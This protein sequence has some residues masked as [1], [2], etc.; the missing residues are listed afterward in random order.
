MSDADFG[1]IVPDVADRTAADL[2][3]AALVSDRVA[4]AKALKRM[5]NIDR[6][7]VSSD[8]NPTGLAPTARDLFNATADDDR[9]YR[10]AT[11]ELLDG[12]KIDPALRGRLE[13]VE[14]DDPLALANDRIWDVRQ[15]KFGKAF[16]AVAEPL[17]RSI[18]TTTMAPYRLSRALVNYFIDLLGQEPILLQERQA[19]VHWETFLARHPDAPE[20]EVL[21]PRVEDA[22]ARLS[23]THRD[24]AMRVAKRALERDQAR[25]ALIYSDRALRYA[26]EDG[27]ASDL[28]DEA[29][30]L[31][32]L[33][34][35]QR[36]RSLGRVGGG[37]VEV[38]PAEA[39]PLVLAMLV[40]GGDM[41]DAAEELLTSDPDGPLADE[42]LFALAIAEGESGEE[43]EMWDEI[44]DLADEDDEDSN[45]ARHARALLA[46]PTTNPYG[47]FEAKVDQHRLQRVMWVLFGPMFRG[48][49]PRN[50]PTALNWAIDAP[51]IA[52][53]LFGSP[54]R[55]LQLPWTPDFPTA[56]VAAHHAREY[57]EQNPDGEHAEDVRDW[58]EDFEEHR[59][60]WIAA[61]AVAENDP[62][63][64]PEEIEEMREKA[65][66]QILKTAT[67]EER[68]DMRLLLYQR[69]ARD[70]PT[71]QAGRRAGEYA[72][73]DA[74]DSTQHRI[75]ISRGFLEENPAVAGPRGFALL[76]R[77]LDEDNTNGE[78]H[79]V[80]VGLIGGLEIETAYV[81][82]DGDPDELPVM[83]TE[84]VSE[85]H[86][87][88]IVSQ[89]E[90]T[91]FR[92]AL[93]DADDPVVPDAQR[94]T[95]FERARLGL[96]DEVDYRALAQSS[97]NYTGMR[98]RYGV[99]R[100]R[101]S[102]LPFE[103]VIQGS[104]TDMSLG[105]FPRVLP[106]R[107]TLR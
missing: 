24:R 3:A 4:A 16:N 53:S 70:Y 89:L 50:L 33:Q 21:L 25:L 48:P 92:N 77:L 19:L 34:R 58:L 69:V 79:P 31:L 32:I 96:G 6:V 59:E 42:A 17:G 72:R 67:E 87:A 15:I 71:T 64:D 68:R 66:T 78:L 82:P 76:P 29:A 63:T 98:E 1:A 52:E 56:R 97:F 40:P 7:L 41:Q 102:I 65:A 81:R 60:N 27:P 88:R 30:R 83:H 86:L 55:L 37:D 23:R 75:Q 105:A 104:F 28:R 45:M 26:P 91:S 73:L 8:E 85:D 74:L 100:G 38:A 46:Q 47:A 107:S 101:D 36:S 51:R 49:K 14:E 43:E 95:F 5:E 11:S 61:L 93:L 20:V 44:E 106:P 22:Q 12:G 103:L 99:V 84:T 62:E 35:E 18:M 39:R 9:S 80:G 2:A 90:E 94:D 57:L 54:M 10:A 13:Q